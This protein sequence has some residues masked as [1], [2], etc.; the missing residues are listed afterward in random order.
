MLIDVQYI[1]SMTVYVLGIVFRR[2][3]WT[4]SLVRMASGE[5]SVGEGV[6]F[7][8]TAWQGGCITQC[9]ACKPFHVT[10]LGAGRDR[11]GDRKDWGDRWGDK[12]DWRDRKDWEDMW[13]GR[14]DWGTGGGAGRTW[15]TGGGTRG[16]GEQV[17]GQGDR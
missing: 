3:C 12:E 9:S 5:W 2:V 13:G 7:L 1:H 14:I 4:T 6:R 10:I 8:C 15:E 11:C 16:L 17:G